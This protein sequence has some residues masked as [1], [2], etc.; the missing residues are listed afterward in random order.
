MQAEVSADPSLKPGKEDD[1]GDMEVEQEQREHDVRL[2]P[3]LI[4]KEAEETRAVLGEWLGL[5]LVVLC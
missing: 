1:G 5:P 2:A 3:E 4:G